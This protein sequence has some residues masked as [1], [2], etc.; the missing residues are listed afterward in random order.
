MSKRKL[1]PPAQAAYDRAID[2]KVSKQIDQ[3]R[4][5]LLF[6]MILNSVVWFALGIISPYLWSAFVAPPVEKPVVAF[7]SSGNWHQAYM[8]ERGEWIEMCDGHKMN[9]VQEWIKP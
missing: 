8:N 2:A 6:G 9:D 4:S 5:T 7:T 3:W 1:N